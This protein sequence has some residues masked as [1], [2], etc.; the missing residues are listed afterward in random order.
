MDYDQRGE[1]LQPINCFDGSATGKI[2]AATDIGSDSN[3]HSNFVS[4]AVQNAG[5]PGA[6]LSASTIIPTA[7]WV[8]PDNDIVLVPQFTATQ[9][10]GTTTL[11]AN[12]ARLSA[13]V[14]SVGG[15]VYAVNNTELNSHIA[16]RWYRIRAS[17]NVLLESGTIA[18]PGLDLFFPSI[19]ANANGVIVI[20]F[21]GCGPST[22]ISC[23]AMAG[24]TING[25]TSFGSRLLL[26]AGLN[27]SYHDLN[28]QI[29]ILLDEQALSR[30]GD[31]STL[32]VDPSD[33]NRFWSIQMYPSDSN[34][35]N[36]YIWS[37][38]ITELITLSAPL[39]FIKPAGTNV[40]V[41]WPT[42]LTDY[43][44]QFAT[45]LVSSITW[46]NVTQVPQTNGA[47]VFVQLPASSGRKFFRLKK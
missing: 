32:S 26:Q 21:N 15:V 46:S 8:V 12:D 16:I 44:L 20:A 33:P 41:S 37:T 17:D 43:Q 9:P 30:W 5:G 39:L 45:N 14:Y 10:D 22:A 36:N 42:G 27:S 18:D 3:P 40:T 35:D 31:Y 7:P 47:Q 13:K 25:V 28:E 23:F 11:Q 19:A 38:R 34:P 1:V 2:L 4:F 29:A 6:T 24:Q